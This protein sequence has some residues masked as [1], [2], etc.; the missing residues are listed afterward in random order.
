MERDD[1]LVQIR[2]VVATAIVVFDYV[3]ERRQASV[4][5]VR[6]A[7]AYVAQGW[8]L[9]CAFMVGL[10]GDG[11]AAFILQR[12]LAPGYDGVVKHLVGEPRASMT[13]IASCF[14]AKQ[15]HTFEL[16]VAE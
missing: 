13:G 3:F 6:S 7:A 14:I 8:S 9:E 11:C 2:I 16:K 4:V 1:V 15:A 5:H 12:A 10:A